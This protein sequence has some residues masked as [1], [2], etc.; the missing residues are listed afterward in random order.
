MIWAI[1]HSHFTIGSFIFLCNATAFSFLAHIVGGFM[2]FFERHKK[3]VDFTR[4]SY[5]IIFSPQCEQNFESAE[6]IPL[7]F[8]H[9]ISVTLEVP[10][11]VST[12]S[13]ISGFK[14]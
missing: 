3:K 9:T 8:G 10:L 13:L 7:H 6:M 5:L 12:R 4:P 14:S 11:T 2:L 1:E